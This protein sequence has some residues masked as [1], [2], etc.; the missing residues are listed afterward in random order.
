MTIGVVN[1]S[2]QLEPV[3]DGFKKGLTEL[4]YVDVTYLYDGPSPDLAGLDEIAA[5][6][7]AAKVDLLLAISTPATQAAQRATLTTPIPVIFGP[8]TDPLTAGVVSNLVEPGGNITGVRLGLESEEQRLKWLLE[9]APGIERIYVPYNSNDSSSKSSVAAA[10]SAAEKL[11]VELVLIEA[12]TPDEITFAIENIPSDVQAIFLPQDSLVA[13][14][15]DDFAAAAIAHKLPLCTPTDGQVQRGALLSY[16]FKLSLL[17]EQMAR[18][19]DQV[20]REQIPPG[21]IPV[22]TAE[23]FLSINLQTAKAIQLT[24]PEEILRAADTIIR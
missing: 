11:G 10:Q 13:A 21:E 18:L 19:A 5:K 22:E 6:M 17:G 23:F 15:I 14:R 4:G 2:P 7:V 24:V 3:L 9:I 8:V 1:L 12:R 20:L 16:S